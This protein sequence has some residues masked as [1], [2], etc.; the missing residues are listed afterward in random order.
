MKFIP[1]GVS[2]SGVTG[3]A[4]AL[5]S[6]CLGTTECV[7]GIAQLAGWTESLNMRYA[8]TGSFYNPG[9]YGCMIGVLLPNALYL[10][11][12]ARWQPLRYF[13]AL[14]ILLGAFMLPL[15]LSRTGWIAAAA[16]SGVVLWGTWL[17]ERLK[18]FLGRYP[19]SLSYAAALT[20]TLSVVAAMSGLYLIKPESAQGRVLIWKIAADAA[21]EH[22]P[23]GVGWEKVA[24]AYGDA[25]ERYFSS[26]GYTATEA[27]V[28]DAPEYV[29]NEYLQT[30]IAFGLPAA[31]ILITL[32]LSAIVLYW[33]NGR[34][35]FCGMTVGLAVC[36]CSSYPFQFMSF[37]IT[38]AVMLV[39]SLMQI[40]RVYISIPLI[41]A[42]LGGAIWFCA[43]TPRVSIE[44]EFS[45]GR[46]LRQAGRYEESNRRL[47]S[48]LPRTS[49]PM[50]LNLIG[51][52]YT[53]M[54]MRDSAEYFL[55]RSALRVPNRMYPHYLLMKL[56]ALSP[57]DSLLMK[58]E[59]HRILTMGVKIA[60]PA[61]E[62][63]RREAEEAITPNH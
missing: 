31:V 57:A 44:R 7:R 16:G 37:K 25:Q 23:Y 58:A 55:R 29:F 10:Y 6:L 47:L 24:G 26:D 33:R 3:V 40:R 13:A 49:D 62:D 30:A 45:E 61:V 2:L 36:C 9:P 19:K 60:S 11:I 50:P 28:A 17:K 21:C 12:K 18:P 56:Y 8:V 27:M 43:H 46:S 34:Y 52:N 59:A 48:L 22:S 4:V 20:L 42:T 51:K 39:C 5:G 53:D 1:E 35:G 63:M 41:I 54:G 32:I 38:A 15:S 14:F